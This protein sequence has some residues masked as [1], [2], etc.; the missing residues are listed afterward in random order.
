LVPPV[1][2]WI[3][4]TIP[5]RRTVG[6]SQRDAYQHS[7]QRFLG[8]DNR[9]LTFRLAEQGRSLR[10]IAAEVGVSHETI[11]AMIRDA[12]AEVA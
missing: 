8:D 6:T 4:R 9:R 11:R 5:L 1:A 3:V 2:D 12:A 7:R 10:E